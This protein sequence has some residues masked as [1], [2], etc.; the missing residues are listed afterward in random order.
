MTDHGWMS[1]L[2]FMMQMSDADTSVLVSAIADRNASMTT[3][4]NSSNYVLW[5]ELEKIGLLKEEPPPPITRLDDIRVFSI[6]QASLPLLEKL[7]S[8]FKVR[9]GHKRLTEIFETF[10]VPFAKQLVER[11]YGEGGDNAE[12]QM[13]MGL[14][15]ASVLNRC[16]SPRDYNS[17]VQSVADLAKRRL[18]GSA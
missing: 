9:K 11:T 16:I 3:I 18:S 1:L 6:V 7:I 12:V 2:N 14:T 5:R 17:S 4:V 13:L 8:D 15:L 10:C